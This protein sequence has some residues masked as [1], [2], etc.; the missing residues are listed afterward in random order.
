MSTWA[1]R[2]SNALTLSL[3]VLTHTKDGTVRMLRLWLDVL[4][5]I[6]MLPVQSDHHISRMCAG[7]AQFCCFSATAPVQETTERLSVCQVQCNPS[8]PFDITL[9]PLARPIPHRLCTFQ[10]HRESCS[11]QVQ[12][13][14]DFPLDIIA[15]LLF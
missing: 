8:A 5:G 3:L 2:L 15:V 11:S 13:S 12:Q 1:H 10:A 7:R 9:L 6:K 14:C 4:Q